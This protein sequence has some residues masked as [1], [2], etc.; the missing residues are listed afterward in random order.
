MDGAQKKPHW[1]RLILR[2]P[3]VVQREFRTRGGDAR[4]LMWVSFL[5]GFAWVRFVAWLDRI[6]S[7]Q[8]AVT[9]DV[10]LG[11]PAVIGGYHPHHIAAGVFFLA[12]AGWLAIHYA[13]PRVLKVIS[14][15]YGVGLAFAADEVG[16]IVEGMGRTYGY[17]WEVFTLVGLIGG[18]MMTSVYF[19]AFWNSYFP[20]A[21]ARLERRVI[22]LVRRHPPAP[23]AVPS[24]PT[25]TPAPA[26]P[27]SQP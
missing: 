11:S 3:K 16:Y 13:G 10:K 27:P 6:A 23:V 18:L 22:A 14:L 15:L 1:T 8:V 19:P 5:I 24:T 12:V 21:W 26:E 7:T 2:L 4:F 20:N 25:P 17:S 9:K